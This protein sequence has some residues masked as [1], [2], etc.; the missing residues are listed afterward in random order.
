MHEYDNIE[1]LKKLKHDGKVTYAQATNRTS[2]YWR[3]TEKSW[4][5]FL[6]KLST[7]TRTQETIAEYNS[8]KKPEQSEI[9]D[10]GG[11]VGGYLK[12]GK[13][14]KGYVMNRS[15]LTRT[16]T[17][18]TRIWTRLLTC[19]LIMPTWSTQRINTEQ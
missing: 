12:E 10:V 4:S 13:R 6:K 2:V 9:K 18:P 8:M 5:D 14:R 7:T 15:M 16:S 11:F 3:N 1:P 17:L 19:S